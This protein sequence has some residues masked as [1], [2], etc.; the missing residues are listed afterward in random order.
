MQF[1]AKWCGEFDNKIE[2]I[3]K[4]IGYGKVFLSAENLKQLLIAIEDKDD[5]KEFKNWLSKN[6]E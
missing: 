3:E 4:I 5:L 1:W 6:I 2:N